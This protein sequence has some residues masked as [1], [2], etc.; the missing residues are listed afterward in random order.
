LIPNSRW[1]PFFTVNFENKL[2][3]YRCITRTYLHNKYV[4]LLYYIDVSLELFLGFQSYLRNRLKDD[5]LNSIVRALL[6]FAVILLL[7]FS[8]FPIK[9]DDSAC[10]IAFKCQMVWRAKRQ[11]QNEKGQISSLF[12]KWIKIACS[13][14]H[15]FPCS[16]LYWPQFI[17]IAVRKPSLRRRTFCRIDNEAHEQ[18]NIIR[19]YQYLYTS[20]GERVM[21]YIKNIKKKNQRPEQWVNSGISSPSRFEIV[22]V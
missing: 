11:Q 15:R 5:N 4:Y 13:S 14:H 7:L 9:R 19:I 8:F 3:G 16:S 18:N 17:L 2:F 6:W 20:I 12:T 1:F 21:L 22:S 10:T